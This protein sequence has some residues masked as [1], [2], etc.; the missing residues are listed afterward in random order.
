MEWGE[1]YTTYDMIIIIITGLCTCMVG[2]GGG[3]ESRYFHD[4]HV[5]LSSLL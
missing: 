3:G 2:K 5:I 1:K 4:T